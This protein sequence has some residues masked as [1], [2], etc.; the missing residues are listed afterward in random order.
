VSAVLFLLPI[1]IALLLAMVWASWASRPKRPADPI[2]SVEEWSRAIRLLA[3]EL[4]RDERDLL[5]A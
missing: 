1:P 3:P 2:V 5:S 4:P